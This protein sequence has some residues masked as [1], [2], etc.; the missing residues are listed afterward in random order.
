MERVYGEEH[1]RPMQLRG[2]PPKGRNIWM[3]CM[4][5]PIFFFFSLSSFTVAGERGVVKGASLVSSYPWSNF[6]L[7]AL[8]SEVV[9]VR[10]PDVPTSMKGMEVHAYQGSLANEN[11]RFRVVSTAFGKHNVVDGNTRGSDD[12]RI[13]P[14]CYSKRVL[15]N[16]RVERGGLS[17]TFV[18]A[19]IEIF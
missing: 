19:V 12:D 18:Q 4:L 13:E 7:P 14:K 5:A 6:F 8:R 10:T 17:R 11:R 15:A 1:L 9:C 2:P 16:I 3:G